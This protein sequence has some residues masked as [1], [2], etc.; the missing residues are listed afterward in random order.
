MRIIL[1]ICFFTAFAAS[2]V[3]AQQKRPVMSTTST[4]DKVVCKL[5][6][7]ELRERKATVVAE[8]KTLILSRQEL[9]TGYSYTFDATDDIL[10]KLNLFIKTERQCCSFFTFQLTVGESS[11]ILSIT[12]SEEAKEFLKEEI[13][14]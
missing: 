7:A 14:L 9:A 6:T 4:E 5:T 8:L 1:S 13:D 10:D 3:E 2:A 11:V 12:G